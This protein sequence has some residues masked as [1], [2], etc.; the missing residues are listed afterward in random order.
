M[1]I[2]EIL[3]ASESDP[4]AQLPHAGNGITAKVE[5]AVCCGRL[6]GLQSTGV[7][8]EEIDFRIVTA[9]VGPHR[10]IASGQSEVDTV[11]EVVA[12]TRPVD[13]VTRAQLAQLHESAVLDPVL[14]DSLRACV[15]TRRKLA[16]IA[17][18][19]KLALVGFRI[20]GNARVVGA[21]RQAH[22]RFGVNVCRKDTNVVL[23]AGSSSGG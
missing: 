4:R 20:A 22:G 11:S 9:V 1:R 19:K 12:N 6:Y 2:G 16:R 3:R 13:G 8:T 5:T 7:R 18:G 23:R 17:I 14:E 15:P 10:E 21:R